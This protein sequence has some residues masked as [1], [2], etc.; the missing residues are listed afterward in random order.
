MSLRINTNVEAINVQQSGISNNKLL[1]PE[2]ASSQENH[3]AKDDA[4]DS[5]SPTTFGR[6]SPA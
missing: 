3:S 2:A 1:S 6:I 5:L 4:S